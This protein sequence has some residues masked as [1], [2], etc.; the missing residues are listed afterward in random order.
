MTPSFDADRLW[1]TIMAISRIGATQEVGTRRLALSPEG[2]EAR[3]LLRPVR[4]PLRAGRDQQYF[5]P[6]RRKRWRGTRRRLRQPP[7]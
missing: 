5:P 2:A 3:A 4:P 7:R 6:L 1:Q